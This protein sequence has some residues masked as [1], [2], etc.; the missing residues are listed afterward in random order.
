MHAQD[1]PKKKQPLITKI[2]KR[3]KYAKRREK[4]NSANASPHQWGIRSVYGHT[5]LYEVFER[6]RGLLAY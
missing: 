6:P 1:D 4:K 2:G 5:S 3:E